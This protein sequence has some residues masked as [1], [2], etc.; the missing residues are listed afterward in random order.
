MVVSA[1]GD[2][3]KSLKAWSWVPIVAAVALVIGILSWLV[4]GSLIGRKTAF[5]WLIVT[6][7]VVV[8]ATLADWFTRDS[9][10]E[11]RGWARLRNPNW[12]ARLGMSVFF[13]LGAGLFVQ[14]FI[15]PTD[16]D[17]IRSDIGAVKVRQ[18]ETNRK[19]D[20]VVLNTNPKPWRAFDSITG[21]WGEEQ[22]DCQ[23]IYRFERRDH[24]LVVTLI[25]KEPNMS[26]YNMVASIAPNGGGDVLNATLRT[27]TAPDEEHGQALVFTYTEDGAVKRLDWLNEDRSSAGP[28]RLEACGAPK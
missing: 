5:G 3:M 18:D 7:L 9:K 14:Q 21:Y 20:E 1:M 8:A 26:D 11:V 16:F 28:T 10:G 12:L 6:F 17:L 2:T 15:A 25:R 19:L 24:G 4:V 13:G 23:V 27:S 22:R